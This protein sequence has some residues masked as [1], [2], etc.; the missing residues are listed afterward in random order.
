MRTTE[1]S[2]QMDL[3]TLRSKQKH[4]QVHSVQFTSV[5]S[6]HS[7]VWKGVYIFMEWYMTLKDTFQEHT[8]ASLGA[9]S[10]AQ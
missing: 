8:R 6:A 9:N 7:C 1:A 3:N 2:R 10:S 5:H 4:L